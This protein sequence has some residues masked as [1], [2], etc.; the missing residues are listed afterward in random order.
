MMFCKNDSAHNTLNFNSINHNHNLKKSGCHGDLFGNKMLK[1]KRPWKDQIG[2]KL[3]LSEM[4]Y[5]HHEPPVTARQPF[6]VNQQGVAM[7]SPWRDPHSGWW[8]REGHTGVNGSESSALPG[9]GR[10]T[11][12]E[13]GITVEA[14]RLDEPTRKRRRWRGTLLLASPP[15]CFT[16]PWPP[17]WFPVGPGVTWSP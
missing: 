8:V 6:I 16:A 14:Q 17:S 5:T 3:M 15:P 11:G 10:G 4:K 7:W 12:W 2:E 9:A 1:K 13:D